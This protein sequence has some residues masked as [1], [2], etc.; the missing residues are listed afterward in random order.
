MAF[1]GKIRSNMWIVFVI[2]ALATLSFIMMDAQGPGGGAVSDT[3]LGVVNGKKIDYKEFDMTER[4]LFNNSAQEPL[5][6]RAGLWDYFINKAIVED[7][8]EEIGMSVSKNELMELQFGQSLSPIIFQNYRTATGQVDI[9]QL[10]QIKNAIQTNSADI[11]PDFRRYWAEQE[12]QIIS[13]QLQ[14]KLNTL[15]QKGLYTPT[16]MAEETYKVQNTTLDIEVIKIPFDD[17]DGSGISVTD[18]DL[19]AYIK[20]HSKEYERKD[21]ERVIQY[22]TMDVVPNKLDS[23]HWRAEMGKLITNFKTTNNDSLFAFANNGNYQNYY[24]KS[25]EMQEQI[26]SVAASMKIGEIYG[27]YLSLRN[28]QAVKLLDRRIV[29][30][31]VRASHI[32]INVTAGNI[33]QLNRANE[34]IDSL[35]GAINKGSSFSDLASRFSDDTSN[36]INGG[37]LGTFTQGTRLPAFNDI[38]FI[39]G[40]KGGVYKVVT[41][42]GVH[43]LKVNDRIFN[44]RSSKYKMAYI[45]IPIIPTKETQDALY[46][47]MVDLVSEYSYL[48]GLTEKVNSIANLKIEESNSFKV[49]DYTLDLLGAGNVTRDI[50][51]FAF[52]GDTEVGDLS[53]DVYT[54]TDDQLYYNRRYVA[55]GLG[56]VLEPGLASAQDVRDII[57][58]TVMNTKKAKAYVSNLSGKSFAAIASDSEIEIDTILNASLNSVFVAGLGNE[59]KVMGAATQLAI[60]STSAP[61]VG[62]SG[63]FVIRKIKDGAAGEPTGLVGLKSSLSSQAKAAKDFKLINALREKSTIKDNRSTFY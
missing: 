51:K 50:I 4:V 45:N 1:I 14:T 20:A 41:Q 46:T 56:K 10:T 62:N 26:R 9:A 43:L 61:I 19:N 16:W 35:Q 25:E 11:T 18:A 34:L 21:E 44:N 13:T 32:L 38:C 7:E 60:G 30:D 47:N 22:V 3:T 48:D 12:K 6:R 23:M 27:P 15:M 37:D 39:K 59:P 33:T 17:I 8:A 55:A 52:S 53:H 54:Y 31:S 28:L 29:P 5:M 36:K 58:A 49:N 2:I 63:V 40:R 42:F 57:E 24:L